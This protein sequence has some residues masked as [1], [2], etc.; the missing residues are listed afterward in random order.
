MACAL[1]VIGDAFTRRPTVNQKP[2]SYMKNNLIISGL[3]LDLT[4]P[5]K[6]L[7]HD[8]MEKIFKIM[9]MVYWL[10]DSIALHQIVTIKYCRQMICIM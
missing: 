7:V 8:K 5:L 2:S 4:V 9:E 1:L 10:V 6:K 3:H